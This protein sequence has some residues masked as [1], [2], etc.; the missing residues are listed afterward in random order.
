[1]PRKS[2]QVLVASE[3]CIGK[4]INE[5]L[6]V[7]GERGEKRFSSAVGYGLDDLKFGV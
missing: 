5:L 4:Q 7:C 1:M 3:E 6:I 2:Q